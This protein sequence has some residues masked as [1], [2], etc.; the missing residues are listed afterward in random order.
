M[1]IIKTRPIGEIFEYR[2]IKLQVVEKL[3]CDGRYFCTN[4]DCLFARIDT[5]YCGEYIREDQK[6]VIFKRITE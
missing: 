2:A 1:S 4:N 3:S 6:N 5:G